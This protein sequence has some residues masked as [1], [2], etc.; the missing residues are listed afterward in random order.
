MLDLLPRK[1]NAVLVL[2]KKTFKISRHWAKREKGKRKGAIV[3]IVHVLHLGKG[4]NVVD[5][6]PGR[7]L[8]TRCVHAIQG[9]VVTEFSQICYSGHKGVVFSK[10]LSS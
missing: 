9:Q 6:H 10:L 5:A 1:K 2:E 4:A 8:H 7:S 3:E